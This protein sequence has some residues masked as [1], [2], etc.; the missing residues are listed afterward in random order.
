MRILLQR[1]PGV[2]DKL[3]MAVKK[4]PA[5]TAGVDGAAFQRRINGRYGLGK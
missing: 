2:L 1:R 5:T 4:H 3:H